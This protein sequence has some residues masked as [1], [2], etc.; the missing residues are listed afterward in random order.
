VENVVSEPTCCDLLVVGGGINGVGIARDAAGRGLSVVLCEQDDLASHTSSASSKLIHGGL[1]YLEYYEFSLVSK[2]LAEREV[3][4]RAAP[5]IVWPMRF[6]MPH[7]ATLR[8]AW[9][10]RA[11][12]FLYDHLDLGKRKL[13]PGS[14][15]I[16]L[17]EHPAGEPLDPSLVSGFEYSDTWVQDARLVV[18][19]AMDAAERG[20]TV[21]TRTR[22]ERAKRRAESWHASLRSSVDGSTRVVEARGLVN[23][24]GPW[25][26]QFLEN[27]LQIPQSSRIRQVKGSHIVVPSLFEHAYAYIFQNPDGRVVFALPYE[28]RFTL[29]GTTEAEYPGD[30]AGA[31]ISEVE[32][33]YLCEAANRYFV[34]QIDPTDVVW[35]FSGVRPLVDDAEGSASAV[36][37]DYRLELDTNGAPL[38]SVFGGKLTTYRKLAEETLEK[39]VPVL[40]IDAGTWTESQPLPGGDIAD[41]DFE[42]FLEELEYSYP[43]LPEPLAH[44]YARAYGTR[45]EMLLGSATSLEDL[46]EHLGDDVYGAEL[47]YLVTHEWARTEEDVLWRRSKLGLHVT[48][49]TAQA[50][51]HWLT[52]NRDNH[53]ASNTG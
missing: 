34:H 38:L 47:K 35:S 24:T 53:L 43:W 19:N 46:G 33:G 25:V 20:A 48:E 52:Q 15:G 14:K 32:I 18:L 5:H 4:L 1:R 44:R 13:L 7:L 23:A 22:C 41:A 49:D 50:V 11:G 16:R 37:R 12:L 31:S 9:M 28:E 21:L 3:V 2:A 42:Q 40:G 45:V 6:V 27:T 10:I 26:S 29:I 30:P 39:L 51:A 17:R 36:T 8:P